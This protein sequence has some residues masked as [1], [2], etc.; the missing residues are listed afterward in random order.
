M[1]FIAIALLI[2]AA[3]GGGASVAAQNSLPGDALWGFKVGINENIEAAL[4]AEGK[5]QADFDIAAIETRMN[6]ASRLAADGRLDAGAQAQIEANF[7]AHAASVQAQIERLQVKGDYSGAA[8][9]AAR[10]QATVAAHASA[11]AGAKANASANTNASAQASLSKLIGKVQATLD[12][13]NTL[14]AEAST[15]AAA[16]ADAAIDIRI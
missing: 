13:A 16:N 14:S 6:E 4:A 8:D 9:V 11:L 3:L 10:F 12:T 7:D 5:A 1:P 15:E 2:A